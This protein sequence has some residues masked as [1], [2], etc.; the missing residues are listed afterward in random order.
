MLFVIGRAALVI[1]T[2]EY[3][4]DEENSPERQMRQLIDS[5]VAQGYLSDSLDP[6][7]SE[8]IHAHF[9]LTVVRMASF[10]NLEE[11]ALVKVIDEHVPTSSLP[12]LYRSSDAFVIP[13]HGTCHS[14]IHIFFTIS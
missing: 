6:P 10:Y 4:S 9:S 5:E 14:Q 12:V 1:L 3:H 8:E 13:P 11:V 2:H 7:I